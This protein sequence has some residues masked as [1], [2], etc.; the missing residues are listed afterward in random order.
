MVRRQSNRSRHYHIRQ[1][2][3]RHAGSIAVCYAALAI[4]WIVCTDH[5]VNALVTDPSLLLLTE[6]AKCN[7][8][9]FHCQ[10]ICVTYL[11]RSV[12]VAGDSMLM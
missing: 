11:K 12:G 8:A 5:L 10:M 6:I 4:L 9:G 3:L 7:N 2:A 1:R